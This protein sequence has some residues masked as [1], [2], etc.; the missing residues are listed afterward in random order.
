MAQGAGGDAMLAFM[1]TGAATSAWVVAGIST[2]MKKRV[3]G[4]YVFFILA[5][6]ILSG[7]LYDLFLAAAKQHEDKRTRGGISRAEGINR[8]LLTDR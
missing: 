6:G 4:V 3:I 8:L 5:G 1:I 7:Y 2:F